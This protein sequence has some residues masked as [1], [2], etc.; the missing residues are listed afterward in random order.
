MAAL[1]RSLGAGWVR[2]PTGM[3]VRVGDGM[4]HRA[5]ELRGNPDGE[6]TV[7]LECGAIRPQRASLPSEED[8]DCMACA[9]ETRTRTCGDE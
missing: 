5:S 6:D 8:V 1:R 7:V 9:I 2:V 4:V 3:S